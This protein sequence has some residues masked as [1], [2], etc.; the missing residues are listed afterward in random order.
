MFAALMLVRLRDA[1][2]DY[3]AQ[4]SWQPPD[5]LCATDLPLA[6]ATEKTMA[7]MHAVLIRTMVEREEE[8]APV[9]AEKGSFYS[10]KNSL[11][12]ALPT[13]MAEQTFHVLKTRAS[14]VRVL[15][16]ADD[17]RNP[18]LTQTNG[19]TFQAREVHA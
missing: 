15:H 10:I 11:D 19:V 2:S 7:S 13:S 17:L 8:L 5:S 18:D 16:G 4:K 1:S 14:E 12:P 9:A 6:K 3:Q